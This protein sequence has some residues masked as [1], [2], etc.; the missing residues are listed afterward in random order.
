MRF[1]PGPGEFRFR[2]DGRPPCPTGFGCLPAGPRPKTKRNSPLSVS[3][4]GGFPFR[5]WACVYVGM[6][7]MLR[8]QRRSDFV[9]R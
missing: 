8:P 1:R 9:T 3:D 6:A 2:F 4:G 5:F 7:V